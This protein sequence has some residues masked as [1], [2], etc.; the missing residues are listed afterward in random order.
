MRLIRGEENED[1]TQ[2]LSILYLYTPEIRM[3]EQERK[4][5]RCVGS[6]FHNI[7]PVSKDGRDGQE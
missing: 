6:L 2:G 4:G 5:E 3:E 7:S 1:I